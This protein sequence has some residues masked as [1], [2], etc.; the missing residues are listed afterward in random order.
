MFALQRK[1]KK[2]YMLALRQ[3][4]KHNVKTKI[5]HNVKPD[6]KNRIKTRNRKT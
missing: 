6:I 4:L 1:S 2:N 3:F 5:K